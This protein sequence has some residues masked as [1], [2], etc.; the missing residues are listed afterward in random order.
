MKKL[1]FITLLVTLNSFAN[2]LKGTR[3]LASLRHSL[4]VE[5]ARELMGES[6]KRS[7]VSRYE[8]KRDIEKNIYEI[9]KNRIPK[10]YRF[11]ALSVGR[12]IIDEAHKYSL[13]PYFILAVISGESN[14]NPN[15]IG[16]VGEIG[17]MQI[18][19]STGKWIS[20]II[21]T[22]WHGDRSLRDPVYNIKL[23]AAY[24]S[25]LRNKFQGHGQLYLA[26]YNMGP[27]SVRRAV[28]KNIYPKDYP[29]HVMKRYVAFYKDIGRKKGTL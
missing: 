19:P 25:W 12:T 23:G 3:S 26:A 17:M 22:K 28:S 11:R 14:F 6:Y 21:K 29:I 4:R 8:N 1:I 9:V 24:L 18:R 10:N 16:P 5:H 7:I 2:P 27:H 20:K 13:D 15:A